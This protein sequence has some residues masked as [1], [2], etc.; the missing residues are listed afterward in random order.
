MND[1]QT[2]ECMKIETVDDVLQAMEYTGHLVQGLGFLPNDQLLLRLV[3]EEAVVNAKEYSEKNGDPL[4]EVG[5]NVS[6]HELL[7][8]VKQ[9][10]CFF[11]ISKK[12][13][14]NVGS[15]G[16]GLQLILSI[17]DDVWLEKNGENRITLHM[18][19]Y[20]AKKRMGKESRKSCLKK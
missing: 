12:D 15:R 16:R 11:T 20:L 8:S 6:E 17:M 13:E 18:K 3:T 9:R 5:W 1:F 10:G 2:Q 4:V 14:I 19:K 7:I